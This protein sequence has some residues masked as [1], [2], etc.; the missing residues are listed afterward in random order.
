MVSVVDGANSVCTGISC[1]VKENLNALNSDSVSLQAYN[2][3]LK[4][5][6]QLIGTIAPHAP[7]FSSCV[8]GLFLANGL[9]SLARPKAGGMYMLTNFAASAL[10]ASY[11][12]NNHEDNLAILSQLFLG[13]ALVMAFQRIKTLEN[14]AIVKDPLVV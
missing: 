3:A 13:S 4:A 11:A 8:G 6:N 10:L 7:Q 5:L 9:N 2:V 1:V 14:A 12:Y